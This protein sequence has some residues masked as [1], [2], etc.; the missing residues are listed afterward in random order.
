MVVH[1]NGR[2]VNRGIPVCI[3]VEQD[4]QV[5]TIKFTGLP[6]G[7][8]CTMAYTR[9]DGTLGAEVLTEQAMVVTLP[10]TATSGDLY[11]QLIGADGDRVWHSNPF[12]IHVTEGLQGD[13]GDIEEASEGIIEKLTKLTAEIEKRWR[14]LS[15]GR[16]CDRPGGDLY[17]AMFH[18]GVGECDSTGD[19]GKRGVQGIEVG[20]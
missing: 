7:M 19:G 13:F 3:G 11:A 9:A 16:D 15:N 10:L 2:T 17:C 20:A 8:S 18:V 6:E 1:I 12:T 4:Q 14:C 5:E